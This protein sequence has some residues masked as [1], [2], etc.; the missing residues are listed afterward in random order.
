MRS[1]TNTP[2]QF[3]FDRELGAAMIHAAKLRGDSVCGLTRKVL[4]AWL[5]EQAR[6]P[7]MT[8]GRTNARAE[9]IRK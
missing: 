3:I 1:V 2:L 6:A 9:E 5:R 4:V 7:A 8:N